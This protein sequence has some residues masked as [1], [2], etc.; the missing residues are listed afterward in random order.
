M[1]TRETTF[2]ETSFREKKPSGKVTIR[3][4]TVY[5]IFFTLVRKNV[6]IETLNY[7]TQKIL[8]GYTAK[9]GELQPLSRLAP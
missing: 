4:T 3:E 9:T 8:E 2:R 6:L 5:P 1:T 7:F